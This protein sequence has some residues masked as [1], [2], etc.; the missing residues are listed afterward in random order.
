MSFKFPVFLAAA[1]AAPLLVASPAA[2]AITVETFLTKAA[3]LRANPFTAL[4]NP[5]YPMLKAEADAATREL[6]ADRAAR[7]AAGKPPIACLPEGESLGILDM[8]SGLDELTPAEK[9][10]PLKDGYA[11]VLAKRF[12]CG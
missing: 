9:R 8:L 10:L 6:K 3:P 2:A 5:D 11:R 1:V 4:T 7:A 12:P